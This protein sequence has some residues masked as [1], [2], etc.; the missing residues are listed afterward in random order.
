MRA[1]FSFFSR[2]TTNGTILDYPTWTQPMYG[3]SW[4]SAAHISPVMEMHKSVLSSNTWPAELKTRERVSKPWSLP[5][6]KSILFA[7]GP[8]ACCGLWGLE[9]SPNDDMLSWW[10]YLR[11]RLEQWKDG[12][13]NMSEGLTFYPFLFVFKFVQV[14]IAKVYMFFF[15]F[16][17]IVG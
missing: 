3:V 2:Y 7:L 9:S 17:G 6:D 5:K 8:R 16:F 14:N 1:R 13:Q 15:F 10:L 4:L 12:V 11:H